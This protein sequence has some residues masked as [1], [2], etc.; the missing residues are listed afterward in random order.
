M[1]GL[2]YSIVYTVH[3]KVHFNMSYE[4]QYIGMIYSV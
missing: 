1:V 4:C 3:V 2:Y